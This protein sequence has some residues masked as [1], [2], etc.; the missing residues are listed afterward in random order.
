M[1]QGGAGWNETQRDKRI[2]RRGDSVKSEVMKPT[3]GWRITC[4][5][6]NTELCIYFSWR[7]NLCEILNHVKNM[8]RCG[9]ER[10]REVKSFKGWNRKNV[11]VIPCLSLRRFSNMN[12]GI[13]YFVIS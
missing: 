10:G 12:S 13:Y 6:K 4:R 1:G 2:S 8:Q 9:A 7:K 5:G 11:N 3:P